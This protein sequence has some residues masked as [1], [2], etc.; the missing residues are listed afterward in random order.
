VFL[1]LLLQISCSF[2]CRLQKTSFLPTFYDRSSFEC[3]AVI[4]RRRFHNLRS[5]SFIEPHIF[6]R[7][8]KRVICNYQQLAYPF[9]HS[10]FTHAQLFVRFRPV[11]HT[12]S[13]TAI[14]SWSRLS[15]MKQTLIENAQ[16]VACVICAFFWSDWISARRAIDRRR[17]R[18]CQF[19]TLY[20][21]QHYK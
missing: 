11:S 20:K 7:S 15:R 4:G 19:A 12:A 5:P 3:T 10:S 2:L 18:R 1:C 8:N 9:R 16:T 13:L 6:R 14:Y 17:R 21:I